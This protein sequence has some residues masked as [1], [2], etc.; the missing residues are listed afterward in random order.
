M[1]RRSRASVLGVCRQQCL[2]HAG[3]RIREILVT[4]DGF[5]VIGFAA[6]AE[7]LPMLLLREPPGLPI[8]AA[9]GSN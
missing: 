8:P 2:C 6:V 3:K 1:R 4:I 5:M 7:L 9:T